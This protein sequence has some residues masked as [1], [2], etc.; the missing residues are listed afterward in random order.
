MAAEADGDD[1]WE[2]GRA[3][4]AALEADDAA[5]PPPEWLADKA[6]APEPTGE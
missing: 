2:H 5:S 3:L 4:L 6:L 1:V